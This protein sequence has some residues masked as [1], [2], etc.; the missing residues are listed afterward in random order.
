MAEE[1]SFDIVCKVDMQEV[2]NAVNQAA[3]EIGQRFDFKGSKSS[4]ELDKDKG[5]IALI[6]EDEQKLR[7]VIDILQSKLVKRKVPLKTLSYG[8]VEQAA[9]NTVRQAVALQQGIPQEKGK[10]LVKLIKDIKLKVAV[11]IQKDQVRV[12]GKKTDDLQTIIA[13]LKERDLGVHLQF[14][15]FR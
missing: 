7:S 8:K 14:T 10:E 15:N 12:R 13:T 2:S 1:H 11:E 5:I 4:V 6:S 9:G 3:K